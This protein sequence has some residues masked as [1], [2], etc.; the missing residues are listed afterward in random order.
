MEKK[1]NEP[2]ERAKETL[3]LDQKEKKNGKEKTARPQGP[4]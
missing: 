2:E 3:R 1:D 4:K